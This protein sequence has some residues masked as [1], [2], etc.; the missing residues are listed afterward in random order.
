MEAHFASLQG[1]EIYFYLGKEDTVHSKMHS[2][3][4]CFIK[5]AP[6][7]SAPVTVGNK[8]YYP[9]SIAVPPNKIS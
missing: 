1:N 4:S 5:T 8:T 3:T 2:L 9:I 7:D 6:A